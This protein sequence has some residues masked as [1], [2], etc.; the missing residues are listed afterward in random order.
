[1]SEVSK[2]QKISGV[3]AKRGYRYQDLIVAFKLLIKKFREV[4]YEAEGADYI[5]DHFDNNAEINIIEFYQCKHQGTGG[6]QPKSFFREVFPTFIKIYHDYAKKDKALFFLLETNQSFH[7]RLKSFFNSCLSLAVNR[8]SIER[9]FTQIKKFRSLEIQLMREL[10]KLEKQ[11]HSRFLR[12]I[13]GAQ[14]TC[15]SIISYLIDFLKIRFPH[16]YED[17]IY[18]IIGYIYDQDQGIISRQ[19][20]FNKCKIPHSCF[21]S[22]EQFEDSIESKGS[23]QQ[24][25]DFHDKIRIDERET[26]SNIHNSSR[27]IIDVLS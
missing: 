11:E 2:R 12:G 22:S 5:Y 23:I 14:L 3:I 13:R 27:R 16:N 26:V 18:Q 9:F 1:M 17:K 6:Y 21:L 4:N 25:K 19:E 24:L 15:E 8:I 10:K 20:L 7:P